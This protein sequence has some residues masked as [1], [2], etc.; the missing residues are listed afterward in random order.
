MRAKLGQYARSHHINNSLSCSLDSFMPAYIVVIYLTLCTSLWYPHCYSAVWFSL[1]VAAFGLV[2]RLSEPAGGRLKHSV[3]AYLKV[4]PWTPT[5]ILRNKATALNPSGKT[6]RYG[7]TPRNGSVLGYRLQPRNCF[8]AIR[9]IFIPTSARLHRN[10]LG[11][12]AN[13]SFGALLRSILRVQ[14]N[15]GTSMQKKKK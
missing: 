1:L 4:P 9:F 14:M 3:L 11:I 13:V 10:I 5:L 2:Q 6:G 7:P 8:S 15:E 12:P